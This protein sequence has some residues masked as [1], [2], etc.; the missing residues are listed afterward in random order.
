MCPA[1][2]SATSA[3]RCTSSSATA[4]TAR[5]W[6]TSTSTRSRSGPPSGARPPHTPP[7]GVA[8]SLHPGAAAIKVLP[9]LHEPIMLHFSSRQLEEQ[10]GM[11]RRS[12][13]CARSIRGCGKRLNRK[14]A[15]GS[16]GG[17]L[18]ARRAGP[19]ERDAR[20]LAVAPQPGLG[21]RGVRRGAQACI[22]WRV[23]VQHEN[24]AL[25]VLALGGAGWHG[26]ACTCMCKE[27]AQGGSMRVCLPCAPMGRASLACMSQVCTS[28]LEQR[29]G[30][31]IGLLGRRCGW[32]GTPAARAP[33]QPSRPHRQQQ[34]RVC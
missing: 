23:G 22:F 8:S 24:V 27:P 33:W 6:P 32:S 25:L 15:Y 19:G 26:T 10:G 4:A 20:A 17:E 9:R 28:W 5:A 34:A 12:H 13:A 11:A 7:L 18:R 16:Q 30:R 31:L 2:G 1:G 29:A 3:G 14:W 21:A